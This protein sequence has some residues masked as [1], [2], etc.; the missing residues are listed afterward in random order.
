MQIA[1]E[2]LAKDT[3]C[4]D[5]RVAIAIEEEFFSAGAFFEAQGVGEGPE[6]CFRTIEWYAPNV[7]FRGRDEKVT[8]GVRGPIVGGVQVVR[9]GHD[10][11]LMHIEGIGA[12]GD[13]KGVSH[14]VR[15]S[16][17]R[18]PHGSSKCLFYISL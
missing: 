9:R 4:G 12:V 14:V 17:I 3:A 1:T 16:S 15:K 8:P 2:K 10:E 6:H 13:E 18:R 7:D 11:S 5:L